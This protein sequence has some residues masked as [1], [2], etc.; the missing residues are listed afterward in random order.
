M[1]FHLF[2]REIKYLDDFYQLNHETFKKVSISKNNK[3]IFWKILLEHKKSVNYFYNNPV[4]E[5]FL[6]VLTRVL[7]Y[8]IY[9]ILIK[10][11]I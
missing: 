2:F 11:F 3:L 5:Q 8:P 6:E 10:F 7:I 4:Q 9:K 1:A